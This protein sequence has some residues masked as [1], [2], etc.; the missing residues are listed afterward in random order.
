MD[1]P[2]VMMR[3]K[4][5]DAKRITHFMEHQNRQHEETIGHLR[6]TAKQIESLRLVSFWVRFSCAEPS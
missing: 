5:T 6:H 2:S 3:G 1:E 4:V